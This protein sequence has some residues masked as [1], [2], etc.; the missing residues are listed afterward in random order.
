LSMRRRSLKNS[1]SDC[2]FTP[3]HPQAGKKS[4]GLVVV[5]VS[6]SLGSK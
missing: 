2:R 5:I 6:T 4:I 3:A 1:I